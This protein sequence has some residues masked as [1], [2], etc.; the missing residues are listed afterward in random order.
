MRR[1]VL[2]LAVA[3]A[4]GVEVVGADRRRA[5]DVDRRVAGAPA[6]AAPA[7]MPA[8]EHRRP[9]RDAQAEHHAGRQRR[10]VVGRRR[11]VDRRIGG[12]GPRPVGPGRIVVRHV[13]E[14]GIGRLDDD[15]AGRMPVVCVVTF[16]CGVVLRLPAA[17]A[18]ARRRWM[19]SATSFCWPII[20]SPIFWVQSRLLFIIAKRLR[21]GDQRL[22]ADVP[23]LGLDRLRRRRRP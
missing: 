6:A 21:K 14:F 10:A 17:A 18:L 19:E 7:P 2:P 5:V 15:G 1:V 3:I 11:I 8:A 23:V 4:V 9:G 22:H 12:I 16:C 20:A 13:D